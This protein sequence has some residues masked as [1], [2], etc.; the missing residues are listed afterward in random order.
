[1]EE[2]Q[3]DTRLEQKLGFD[4][5][6]KAVSDRCSTEYAAARVA[7]E[8]FSTDIEEIRLRLLLADEM[9]LIVMFEESF[10]TNGYIDCLGFLKPLGQPSSAIDISSL[11]KLRTMLET[12][13]KV[14]HF[15]TGITPDDIANAVAEAAGT[16]VRVFYS[17]HNLSADD[18]ENGETYLSMMQKNVET[19]K[20]VL[21]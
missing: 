9:R 6:R 20:E 12:L 13:S 7:E 5:I 17:C 14:T 2:I 21:N 19:L 8:T 10:P 16:D 18:F 15:F 11:R 3:I 1:M 4:R